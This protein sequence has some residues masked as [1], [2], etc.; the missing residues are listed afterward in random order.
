MIFICMTGM[1]RVPGTDG[2]DSATLPVHGKMQD[3]IFLWGPK[4]K[5]LQ[6]PYVAADSRQIPKSR[7]A[8]IVCLADK[9][10]SLYETTTR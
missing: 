6:E 5:I 7:E 3:D 4:K 8:V 9:C 10:C 2:M 1:R